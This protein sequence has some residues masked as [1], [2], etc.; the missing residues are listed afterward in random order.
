MMLDTML[1]KRVTTTISESV[2]AFPAL[3]HGVLCP[4]EACLANERGRW[5]GGRQNKGN[6]LASV[7]VGNAAVNNWPVENESLPRLGAKLGRIGVFSES[8]E[9]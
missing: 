6:A 3:V 4:I 2:P 1:T 7:I 5:A 9:T 8:A